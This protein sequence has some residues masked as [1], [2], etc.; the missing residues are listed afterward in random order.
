[1]PAENV[2]TAPSRRPSTQY[3]ATR[4]I[5]GWAALGLLFLGFELFLFV[6]WFA[7]GDARPTA[8][9][10]DKMSDLTRVSLVLL[11]LICVV[12]AVACIVVFVIL[13]L[14]RDHRLSENG[15]WVLAFTTLVW[16]EPL[17]N[18]VRP[19]IAYNANL[20]NLGSWT[21]RIPGWRSPNPERIPVPL[22]LNG[23]MYIFVIFGFVL[24]AEVVIRAARR[25]WPNLGRGGLLAVVFVFFLGFLFLLEGVVFA[26]TAAYVFAGVVPSLTLW[27]GHEYQYPLYQLVI[28]SIWFT[29]FTALR[30]FSN[31]QGWT[32]AERGAETLEVGSKARTVYRFLARVGACNLV[33]LVTYCVPMNVIGA[34]VAPWPPSIANHSYFSYFTSHDTDAR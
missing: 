14:R 10:P 30:L 26:R 19:Q 32:V 11:Q 22:L 23:L 13:P 18:Y 12:A 16:Q 34:L 28:G 17:L 27:S 8:P 24:F 5:Y 9:G 29:G 2:K 33:F 7:S 1:M 3:L 31:A 15:L 21:A 6:G 20:V 25:R 4:A